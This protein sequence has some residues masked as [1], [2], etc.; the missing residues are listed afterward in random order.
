M[1]TQLALIRD[2]RFALVADILDLATAW[3]ALGD[4]EGSRIDAIRWYERADSLRE[5]V[6]RHADGAQDHDHAW[7]P[8]PVAGNWFCGVCGETVEEDPQ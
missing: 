1:D 2:A 8:N 5:I 7:W 3:H 4:A 6:R